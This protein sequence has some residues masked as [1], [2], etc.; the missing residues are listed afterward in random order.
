[1][2]GF[3]KEFDGKFAVWYSGGLTMETRAVTVVT[4]ASTLGCEEHSSRVARRH[5]RLL[6]IS[7]LGQSCQR[8][9]GNHNE[10][11][12]AEVTSRQTSPVM[13]CRFALVKEIGR[14]RLMLSPLGPCRFS[15]EVRVL[16]GLSEPTS[17]GRYGTSSLPS[18]SWSA[19][20]TAR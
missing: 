19:R 14:V 13:L 8:V 2:C 5:V 15:C 4:L 7:K 3:E 1:M 20:S 10:F 18:A 6:H 12:L 11:G 16:F 9:T 17:Y